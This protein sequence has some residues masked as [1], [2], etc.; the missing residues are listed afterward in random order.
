[1]TIGKRQPD[2]TA[3]TVAYVVLG[4]GHVRALGESHYEHLR[5]LCA[6]ALLHRLPRLTYVEQ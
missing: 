2:R 6:S 1:M 3:E 5:T 4:I